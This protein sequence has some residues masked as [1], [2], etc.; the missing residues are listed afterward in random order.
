[1]FLQLKLRI[2][3]RQLTKKKIKQTN[4]QTLVKNRNSLKRNDLEMFSKLKILS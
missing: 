1:M 2:V 3:M 4:K